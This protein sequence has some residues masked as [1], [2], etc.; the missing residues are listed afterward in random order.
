MTDDETGNR[1]FKTYIRAG[2]NRLRTDFNLLDQTPCSIVVRTT[3]PSEASTQQS[4]QPTARRSG[5][6]QA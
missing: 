2:M 5:S 1:I 6:E 4:E 3:S